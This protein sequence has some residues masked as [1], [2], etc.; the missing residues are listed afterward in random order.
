MHLLSSSSAQSLFPAELAQI[1]ISLDHR[2]SST[3][4]ISI[5]G[6]CL[7]WCWTKNSNA[8]T[9]RVKS[10][11]QDACNIENE[12]TKRWCRTRRQSFASVA[13]S[14]V[15]LSSVSIS[16][17]TEKDRDVTASAF[18]MPKL[19][20]YK[21]EAEVLVFGLRRKNSQQW[22]ERHSKGD[23]ICVYLMCHTVEWRN[24]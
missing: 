3:P 24:D 18:L 21:S 1:A 8:L 15:S 20:W 23:T 16:W 10:L 12:A 11:R 9:T 17:R 22:S 5:V 14:L 6:L 13:T 19:R 7:G 2:A 4:Q